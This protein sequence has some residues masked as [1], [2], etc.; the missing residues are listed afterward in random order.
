MAVIGQ[1]RVDRI[2]NSKPEERRIIFEEV[3]GISR[4]KTRKQEGLRKIAETD[5]NLERIHDMMSVLE[6]QLTPMKEQADKLRQFRGLDSERISYE[7]TLALQELRN[8]ERL[9]S[10]V[11]HVRLS[12]LVEQQTASNP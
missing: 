4:Y 8:A 5:R 7:G 11:E 2:L 3:A 10:K 1:N 12:A 6:E 9:L